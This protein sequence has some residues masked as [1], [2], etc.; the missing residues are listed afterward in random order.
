[1]Q[2]QPRV[3]AGAPPAQAEAAEA[4]VPLLDSL[5][6]FKGDLE[7]LEGQIEKQNQKIKDNAPIRR[8]PPQQKRIV[9]PEEPTEDQRKEAAEIDERWVRYEQLQEADRARDVRQQ[10]AT[11]TRNVAIEDRDRR[12]G[13]A[14]AFIVSQLKARSSRLR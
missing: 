10:A 2:A 6:A 3:P 5:T 9:L 12:A 11:A 1:P 7:R 13:E 8:F 14:T 4:P